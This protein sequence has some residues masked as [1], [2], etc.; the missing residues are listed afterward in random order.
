MME[1]VQLN[2]KGV[3]GARAG[4]TLADLKLKIA[5]HLIDQADVYDPN[6]VYSIMAET[7]VGARKRTELM[8]KVRLVFS[9]S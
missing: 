9:I 4:T 1:Q 3:G 2:K 6:G 8:D 7:K 5:G